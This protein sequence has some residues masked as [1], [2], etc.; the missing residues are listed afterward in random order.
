MA[1]HLLLAQRSSRRFLVRSIH[2][3]RRRWLCV[4]L[5]GMLC[6]VL[7]GRPAGGEAEALQRPEVHPY[8][9]LINEARSG[10]PDRFGG[11][12][13]LVTL[14]GVGGKKWHR[15]WVER[16]SS[17]PAGMIAVDDVV[18]IKINAQW[19]QRGGTNTDVLRGVIRTIVEHPDGFHGEIIVADNGQGSGSLVRTQNNAEDNS[20]STQRVVSDFRAEGWRISAVLWDSMGYTSCKE[21]SEGDD[22]DGYVVNAS[23][24]AV[25]QITVSYPKFQTIDG[26]SIS[27]K[28]GIWNADSESYEADRLKVINIPVLKTHRIYAITAG[29]KNHMG[30]VTR[31]LGTN[32][33]NSVEF[34]GMGS[35]LAEVRMPDLTI[36]DCIW[37]LARPGWGP[38]AGYANA[39]FRNQLVAGT[40]PIALDM[41]A[42]KH[43]LLPQI[44]ENGYSLEAYEH[45]QSPDNPESVFRLYLDRSMQALLRADKLVTNDYGA[46]R[47]RTWSGDSDRDGD[48]DLA[49][50]A[51]LEGC[52]AGPAN[53]VDEACQAF[54]ADADGLIT[55]AD[56]ANFQNLF[57]PLP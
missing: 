17:G 5:G 10:Q 51:Q 23:R 42:A 49:D 37:I 46:V 32:S 16:I 9:F 25:T 57:T 6:L 50:L 27:Y 48:V 33:H 24:D 53:G 40:D 34:G 22:N 1:V 12:D 19:S 54:D 3:W 20:Q 26:T 2:R 56:F 41:W 7:A 44:Q 36:L 11:V 30:V 14:M 31:N 39:S 55:L 18:L 38:Q 4:P 8:V 45:T 29:V 47:L 15:S 13:D 21:Y 28:H 52:L 35:I 43:V